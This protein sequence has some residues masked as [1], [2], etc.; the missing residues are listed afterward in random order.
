MKKEIKV[1]LATAVIAV[2]LVV[3]LFV[4]K[5]ATTP[6]RDSGVEEGMVEEEGSGS[7]AAGS[8]MAGTGEGKR[9]KID[10]SKKKKVESRQNLLEAIY[11]E[12]QSKQMKE[13]L[14]AIRES[15]K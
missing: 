2:V 12:G 14:K 10:L 1:L 7:S 5:A 8:S 6:E 11:D 15:S 4:L 3:G 13:H 9:E